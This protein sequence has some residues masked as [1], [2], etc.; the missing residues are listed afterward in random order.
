MSNLIQ[1]NRK[2]EGSCTKCICKCYSYNSTSSVTST[3]VMLCLCYETEGAHANIIATI[4]NNDILHGVYRYSVRTSRW[5]WQS[6]HKPKLR[7][8]GRFWDPLN[9]YTC[10][11]RLWLNG[12]KFY[13]VANS[14]LQKC[15]DS[16]RTLW[17]N[18]VLTRAR[19]WSLCLPNKYSPHH[20]IYLRP[21]LVLTP[22]TGWSLASDLL[23]SAF[24]L[25]HCMQF[26]CL[27][28]SKTSHPPRFDHCIENGQFKSGINAFL[29][30]WTVVME[31]H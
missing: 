27:L 14:V 13:W 7:C 1:I 11:M 29:K 3:L 20:T 24:R 9:Y 23:L 25:K 18:T 19:C 22:H 2:T 31:S 30:K 8:A 12:A 21:V 28:C 16:Y 26:L 5:K 6:S 10:Y 15:L 17:F 4:N